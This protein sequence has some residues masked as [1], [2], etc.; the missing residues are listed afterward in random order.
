MTTP[1]TPSQVLTPELLLQ[2]APLMPD[3][4]EVL[5]ELRSMYDKLRAVAE[6]G[7]VIA[8]AAEVQALDGDDAR[9]VLLWALLAATC[10]QWPA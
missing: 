2:L 5:G 1:S 3:A 4:V 9:V 7:D 8:L 6:R 10:A